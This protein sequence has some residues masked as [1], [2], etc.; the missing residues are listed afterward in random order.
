[1][2]AGAVVTRSILPYSISGGVIS[3][4][5]KFRFTIDEIIEH[6]RILYKKELRYTRDELELIF[7]QIK[8][9]SKR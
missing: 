2:D 7:D 8:L 1:M 3:K 6:E 5:L 9:Q 4:H